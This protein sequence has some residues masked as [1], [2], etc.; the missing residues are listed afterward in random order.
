MPLPLPDL[1]DRN[2][3]QLVAQ[4]MQ[5]IRQSNTA[6][7]DLSPSDPGVVLLEVFAYLTDSMIYRL[8]R[9]PNKVYIALLRLLGVALHPPAAAGTT[10]RFSRARGFTQAVEIPRGT[11]VTLERS[12]AAGSSTSPVF[13]TTATVT[14]AQDME[15]VEVPALHAEEVIGEALGTASGLPGFAAT[16]QHPP[17]IAPTGE[18]L[19]LIVGIEAASGELNERI[20]AIQYEGVPYRIW[21]EVEN[22]A[23]LGEDRHVY[24]V[25]RMSGTITFAPSLAAQGND[26]PAALG[27][28]PPAGR[29]IRAWYKHGG[30]TTGNV[31]ANTLTVLKDPIRGVQVTNPT[32]ATGGRAAETLENALL[33]GPKELHS[34]Q[35]AVT[36]NDFELVAL[37]TLEVARAKAI[38]RAAVWSYAQRG[39]VELL[40]VP[41]VPETAW[42]GDWLAKATL[43]EYATDTARDQVQMA[44]D[45]RRPLGTT[46]LV[47]WAHYK[48]VRVDAR[49]VVRREEDF[50]A[51]KERVLARLHRVINPLPNAKFGLAGWPF[52]QALRVSNLYD[53]ALAEPGVRW[54]DGVSLIVDEVPDAVTTIA[55][56]AFQAQTWFAGSENHVFRSLNDGDGWENTISFPDEEHVELVRTHPAQAGLVAAITR[57]GDSDS[58]RVYVSAD[59]G[60]SWQAVTTLDFQVED[61]AWTRRDKTPVLL[62]ATD[63]GFY[64]L[65]DPHANSSVVQVLVSAQNQ[66]MSFYAVTTSTDAR[67]DV[68]VAVAAQNSGGVFLS[69][70]GGRSNTFRPIEGMEGLD[71]RML[72]VQAQGPRAWLWAGT[73]AFGDD[74]GKGVYRW[75]LRGDEDPVTGWETFTGNWKAG[76]CRGLTFCTSGVLAATHRSGIMSLDPTQANPQWQT[77]DVN[78]GLPLRDLARGRFVTVGS[79]AANPAG[80]LVMAGVAGNEDQAAGR[81]VYRAAEQ[82]SPFANWKFAS[83]STERF[84]DKV[85][86]PETWLF[87]SGAHEI[88]VVSE[89]ETR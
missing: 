51:V 15:S 27:E 67:G 18:S 24:V 75:E 39:A 57:V 74:T 17:I 43:M 32:P 29:M 88:T 89:D 55:A 53:I 40:L 10:L 76:S 81:G 6:W 56:D 77:P 54:V 9:L 42:Q 47:A 37:K 60:E 65:I 59:C 31:A 44:L 41:D 84:T 86:L 13:I 46:C 33:R 62:L 4:A 85:T 69:S 7:D 25:D 71:V 28:V 63:K 26:A 61:A 8:N 2:F 20:P 5:R 38:T 58:S 45:E 14:L 34:L 48:T 73:F 19:D 21:R 66:A 64:E 68:S 87:A 82:G 70:Q 52:G 78:S 80:T 3:E 35:R 36:A 83:C 23:N 22:F 11:H 49:I 12:S 16:V 1:D 50:A 30:G 72:A 79:I